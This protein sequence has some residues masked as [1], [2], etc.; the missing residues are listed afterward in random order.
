MSNEKDAILG[1]LKLCQQYQS[2]MSVTSTALEL[3]S[4]ENLPFALRVRSLSKELLAN[5]RQEVEIE[6]R[7]IE[8]AL[9]HG[10]DYVSELRKLLKRHL[11]NEQ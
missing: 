4:P 5:R 11:Q 1:L 6:Y 8:S 2:Q 3:L 9:L 7:P 10:N